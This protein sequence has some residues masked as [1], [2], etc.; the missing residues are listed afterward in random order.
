MNHP[1]RNRHAYDRRIS[2][3][4]RRNHFFEMMEQEQH[5]LH[6]QQQQQQ[7]PVSTKVSSTIQICTKCHSSHTQR[8]SSWKCWIS[9]EQSEY[10]RRLG[11]TQWNSHVR[12]GIYV[13]KMTQQFP[14]LLL[15]KRIK[16]CVGWA[17]HGIVFEFLD[18][19]RTGFVVDVNSIENDDAIFKKRPT[20]WVDV[21]PGDFIRSVKGFHLSRGCFL[22]HT[23]TLEL[24][25]G[26][27]IEFA[28]HHEPWK[29]EAF[30]YQLP[31]NA[32]LQH[33]SFHK[34]QC[35]GVTACETNLHLPIK[36][37]QRIPFLPRVC[38]DTFLLIQLISNCIDHRLE[39]NGSKSLGIDLWNSILLEY[40][41]CQDLQPFA[42]SPV[43]TL[44]SKR[45]KTEY[46][47]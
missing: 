6:I 13:Q 11:C 14:E 17:V 28:S 45:N 41:T 16:A 30:S 2:R 44:Q 22:C 7:Q 34:G 32:L 9:R 24:N 12:Q 5:E 39:N 10:Q 4:R 25:S 35:I 43:G 31:E 3:R 27:V 42:C 40:L 20:A 46:T 37:K 1:Y 8:Y 38:R 36:Y 21:Q 47:T 33:V 29:G 18:G 15:L 26:R 19:T 23:L